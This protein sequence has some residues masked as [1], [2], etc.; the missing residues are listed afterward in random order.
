M[1]KILLV[2]GLIGSLSYAEG[3]KIEVRGSYDLDFKSKVESH[4]ISDQ[5]DKGFGIGAEYRIEVIDGLELGG[6]LEYQKNEYNGFK[7]DPSFNGDYYVK[8]TSGLDSFPLYLTA[9]YNFK[10][11][12]EF[13]PYVKINLGYSINSGEVTETL[14][15]ANPISVPSIKQE[16]YDFKNGL[17]YGFGVGITYR[18]FL[19]DLSYEMNEFNLEGKYLTASSISSHGIDYLEYA[20]EKGKIK[21]QK[22]KLSI[23]YQFEF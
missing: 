19:I 8:D 1:K 7:N 22:I 20:D 5:F 9:R 12:S 13:I 15:F 21:N 23:G 3:N 14:N 6:G 2:I 17:Y 18:S 11:S 4:D 16:E 10:N